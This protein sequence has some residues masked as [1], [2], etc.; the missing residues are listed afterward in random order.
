[1]GTF[2]AQASIDIV[3]P[4]KKVWNALTD[5]AQIKKYLFG[6]D[7][8]S[9]WKVGSALHFKGVWEGK[10]YL[11]KGVILRL[12]P[13]KVLEYTYL[14]SF[15]GLPD[16]PENYNVITCELGANNGATRLTIKQGNIAAE[17]D[18]QH[19]EQNWSGVLKAMKDLLEK[20]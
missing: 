11:D 14:S 18:V 15:S 2:T 10:E 20:Q 16:K 13:E 7:A 19:S 3:A 17:K 1:M 12:E 4:S 6:T 9:E 8:V 5:P